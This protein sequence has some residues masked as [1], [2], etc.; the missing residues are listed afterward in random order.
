MPPLSRNIKR[1]RES[2]GLNMKEFTERHSLSYAHHTRVESGM[3]SLGPEL[4]ERYAEVFGVTV[5]DLL[6]P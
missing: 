2:T 1:L 4:R 6:S 3:S 5:E